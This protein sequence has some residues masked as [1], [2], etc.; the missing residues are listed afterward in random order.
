M[1]KNTQ[2]EIQEPSEEWKCLYDSISHEVS[3]LGQFRSLDRQTLSRDGKVSQR[4]GK[5]IALRNSQKEPHLYASISLGYKDEYSRGQITIYIHKAV[6]DHFVPKPWIHD[7][8]IPE[9]NYQHVSHKDG[10][11]SNNTPSNLVWRTQAGL[12]AV[13][14]KR[15]AD[16]TKAWRTR[17]EIYGKSGSPPKKTKEETQFKKG[18]VPF[19]KGL[20]LEQYVSPEA[21]AKI[22]ETQFKKGENVGK[23][24][25]SWTGG[26]QRT[27]RDGAYLNTGAN[28]RVRLSRQIHETQLGGIPNG[29]VV[30]HVDKDNSNDDPDNLI[31]VPR[32]ILVKLNRDLID[33][34]YYG[35]VKAVDD[36]LKMKS[37]Q[38]TT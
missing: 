37:N 1:K 6:A 12:L 16:P 23:D 24:S 34:T 30:Y 38:E 10:N 4:R 33:S 13:Q 27:K 15:I 17:R 26:I 21:I 5:I 36:Y 32:A 25:H 7:P 19:N 35:I 20:S 14:P 9:F 22:K 29:W 3:N 31:A 2:K 18:N 11:H 8:S 28:E